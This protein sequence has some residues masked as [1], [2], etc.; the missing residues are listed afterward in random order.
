MHMHGFRAWVA[1][2]SISI[3]KSKWHHHHSHEGG[4]QFSRNL[5]TTTTV[6]SSIQMQIV[7]ALRSG[8]RR[9]ASELL[10]DFGYKSHPLTSDDFVDIF[11]YCARS[12]DPL[13]VMEM[14]RLMELKDVSMNY[15]CFVLMMQALCNGGYLEEAF[16]MMDFLGES[17]RLHPLLPLCNSLLRS[18]TEMQ[19]IIQASK[20]LD[21]M[22][23]LMV[24]K[25]EVTYTELV[26]LAVLQKNLPAVHLIWQEYIKHYS[27]SILPLRKFIWSFTRLGDLKSAY[28]TLQQMVSLAIGGN[29]S[30]ARTVNGKL[31]STRLDIPVP[32]N[33]ELG[34]TVLDLK[35]TKQ[36]DSCICP[37]SMYFPDSIS[38]S[39]GPQI[40]RVGNKKAKNSKID[41]LNGQKHPL[42]M[43]ILRWSFNDIIH[44]CAK[45]KNYALA[46]KLMLQ[47]QNFGLQP[48]SHTYDGIVRA[49]V[50]GRSFRH[51]MRVL[52]KMQQKNLKPYDPT[53]ATLSIS[54]SEAMQLDL[55]EALLNRISK[56]LYP[57]PYN[58]LL[59]SCDALN[60]PER[61]V[62]VFAKMKQI[63]VLP[64]IRTYEL[65][66]S[67]FG[68]VN[69]PYE[70]GN[71]L[72]QVDAAKRIN[73]IERDMAKNGIQHSHLSIRNLLKALG[74]E[75]MMRELIQ[76]LHVAENLFIYRNPSLGTDMYNIVLH[77]LVE[78]KECHMAIEIFKK[79]KLCG[80]HPDSET[81][82]IMI[83]CCSVLSCYKSASLLISVMIREGFCPMTCTY[84]TLIKILLENE[85]F[86][87]ALNLFER[88]RLDGIQLD[89]LLFNTFLR[90]A[91]YQGRIDVI[92]FIVECMHREKIQ[93][94]P[95]TCGYVFSAYVNS[96]F[97]NTAIEALQVLSLR[98]MSI[99]GNIL[100]Q[101]KNFVDEFILAEDLADE[102]HILK[103]FEDSEDVLV[104]GL[105][106]LRWSVVVGFPICESADQSLWA[107]RL[108]LQFLKKRLVGS[109]LRGEQL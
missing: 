103:L 53:L 87:E 48:S 18:C 109:S 32:L 92:E 81:Y 86:N 55:A 17:Q 105:L 98:M 62:R 77:Y 83:D 9:K 76:Y 25:S 38:A 68:I 80:C 52:E 35:E 85:N 51:G 27:M 73:A 88:V 72:S 22:E 8:E 107:K 60:Q 63:K 74:Q 75:G 7:K 41:G 99:D 49:V 84:T 31:Y 104:V 40:I 3:C 30:I 59:A 16:N 61:A 13:F 58:A 42:L 106:N 24:G 96:G 2:R 21:L 94:N 102:S 70:D 23:K 89:V 44:G 4:I 20:C 14:W 37:P 57:H 29:I 36:P 67:L 10:L 6:G 66:F 79:M 71:M 91:C 90:K 33:R 45:Q 26:K 101:K 108:E 46:R 100:R 11:K 78:A 1:L 15:I 12:P 47:M 82:N 43:K 97:H 69:A 93:P 64:N 56:C 65:L 95:A 19:S 34:S 5:T 28:K 50:S 39:I 54:C